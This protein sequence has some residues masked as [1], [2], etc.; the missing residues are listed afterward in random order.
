M[1]GMPGMKGHRVSTIIWISLNLPWTRHEFKHRYD[2]LSVCISNIMGYWFLMPFSTTFL[3][4]LSNQFYWCRKLE[5]A[6]RKNLYTRISTPSHQHWLLWYIVY[7]SR[8]YLL[9]IF[10]RHYF[11]LKFDDWQRSWSWAKTNI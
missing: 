2:Q 10:Y 5:Y 1:P 4:Y 11:V 7:K 9:I 3:F 8:V 6:E